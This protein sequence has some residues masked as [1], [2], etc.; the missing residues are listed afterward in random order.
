LLST[1]F[2]QSGRELGLFVETEL[3]IKKFMIQPKL[4]L[5]TGDGRISANANSGNADLGG[6][7]YSARL[8]FL[9]LGNFSKHNRNLIA[10]LMHEDKPKFVLGIAASYNDGASNSVGEGQN[11]FMLY[12]VEGNTQ[13]PDYRQLYGDFLLKYKGISLL[14]EVVYGTATNL[15]GTFVDDNASLALVPNEISEYLALGS[16]Y[17]V[18]LGYATKSGYAIDVKYEKLIPEFDSNVNSIIQEADVVGVLL[19]KYFKGNDLKIQGAFTYTM[20]GNQTA[21]VFGGLTCQ[22]VL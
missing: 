8:D 12:N 19:S 4:A 22:V 9:P 14:G 21:A 1:S 18:Q 2:S 13:L 6:L 17:N 15:N 7:K 10:D 3:S 20:F 16:A 5:T 11:D